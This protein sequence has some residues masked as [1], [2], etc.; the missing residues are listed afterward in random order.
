MRNHCAISTARIFEAANEKIHQGSIKALLFA[1]ILEGELSLAARKRDK[2]QKMT[3][4][5]EPLARLKH[6]MRMGDLNF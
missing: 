3:T 5:E 4:S 6:G 1:S 2:N